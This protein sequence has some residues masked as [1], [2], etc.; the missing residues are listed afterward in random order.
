M[1]LDWYCWFAMPAE[2]GI[3]P[4][5]GDSS[6]VS[7]SRLEGKHLP[8]GHSSIGHYPFAVFLAQQCFNTYVHDAEI[9]RLKSTLGYIFSLRAVG[10]VGGHEECLA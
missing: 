5:I 9:C 4:L 1:V 7:C 8:M 6:L 10:A 3:A 2:A